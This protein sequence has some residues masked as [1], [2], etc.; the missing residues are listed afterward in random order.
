MVLIVLAGAL[1]F[2]YKNNIATQKSGA[3]NEP[4][5]QPAAF[6]VLDEKD[7]T[8]LT[9]METY[10][11]KS[12]E[13]KVYA[14]KNTL[15]APGYFEVYQSGTKVF[16]SDPDYLISGLLSFV[17]GDTTYV[18]VKDYSGGAHCCDT[19]YLFRVNPAGQVKLIKTFDIG[20]VTISKDSLLLKNNKL[21]LVL[22]DDRFQYFHTA[23]VDSY[24]FNQYLRLD[25]DAVYAA[26][27]DFAEI[28]AKTAQDCRAKIAHDASD[29]WLNDFLCYAANYT[30][31]G[32]Q[33][34][35]LEDFNGFFNQF[36]PSGSGKDSFGE[37]IQR[38]TLKQEIIETLQHDRFN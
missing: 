20:N 32:K 15:T 8:A 9:G 12:A 19:D 22:I 14:P 37:T 25:G 5:N 18:V 11:V 10:E 31:I 13:F 34:T 38:D 17:F 29:A 2:F 16:A 26:N 21:Y 4:Q 35:A 7:Y 6:S 3:Q 30:L 27:Q 1:L 33:N 24:F 23:Y 36:F 28:I